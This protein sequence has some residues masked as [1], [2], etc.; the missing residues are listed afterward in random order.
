MRI[1]P[2]LPNLSSQQLAQIKAHVLKSSEPHAL[3]TFLASFVN[4]H[5]PQNA[6]VLYNQMLQNSN[7]H[8][9]FSF[10]Y[11]LKACCLTNSFNKGQEIHAHVI[12]SG[13]FSHTYI[14]N[15]FIHFYVIRND[16]AYAYRVFKTIAHPNVVSWTSIISGFAKCG[17]EDNA[18]FMFS[19]MDVDPNANTLVSVLSACSNIRELNLGK[20]VHCYA[21][22][23]SIQRN[24]ILDNALLH[25]YMQ[26]G[27]LEN[28]QYLFAKMP[29]RDVVSWSTMVGGFV[30][31]G[32]CEKAI[33]VFNEMVKVGE[34]KPN[35]ATVVNVMAAC[36]SLGSL[37]LCGWV[38]SYIQERQDIQLEG[39]IGNALVNMYVKCGNM[40]KAIHVFKKLRIKDIITWS[41]MINGV[42]INS[43]GHHA[44]PLLSL[45]LVH[46][47]E[48]DD[49]T[50]ISL[51]TAC[52][53]GG[54]VNE[55]LMLFKAM[56]DS[57]K[58][59]ANER[60]YA[61]VVDLYARGGRVKEAE[62]FVRGMSIEP[63]GYVWGALVNGLR[64]HG[65]EAMI[66]RIG[67]VLVEKGV[68]GGTLALVS[69]SY[70]GLSRWDES[71][72]IRNEMNSLGLKKMVGRS[73][74]ELDV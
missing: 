28:A 12:K 2:F 14:Q 25:F 33:H 73:W 47:V 11:A 27:S 43:L 42:A 10:N 63:D 74:I 3:N 69:N 6:F 52:S 19:W 26:V 32:F 51:L 57:Y 70:V 41:T 50:F 38:H 30:Q 49:V 59:V 40:R 15:S 58:I 18:I 37:S 17:L 9:H 31:R 29:K 55:G 23:N 8:N 21:L 56:V 61:C 5:T 72:E 62:D 7:T 39:N 36:A 67:C 1:K 44:L 65:N 35:E 46:G 60:H 66:E 45:M 34:V 22:K 16:I 48:P 13:H 54:L 68:S 20:A 53:H 24:A 64:V 4:S 71:I